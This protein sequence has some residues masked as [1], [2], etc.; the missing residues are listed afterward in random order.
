MIV[1]LGVTALGCA[2]VLTVGPTGTTQYQA[3]Q[4]AI[5]DAVDGDTV[6]VSP[7]VYSVAGTGAVADL[8]GKRI[9]LQS[10]HGPQWTTIAYE[11]VASTTGRGIRC[12]NSETP[13]T[14]IDGFRVMMLGSPPTGGL[15][16]GPGLQI[17]HA[18]PTIR[19]CSFESSVG[20]FGGSVIIR[21]SESRF[22]SCVFSD[23]RADIGGAIGVHDGSNLQF[24]ECTFE[25]NVSLKYGGGIF[26]GGNSW[27]HFEQC[28]FNRNS[29]A[30]NGGGLYCHG[31]YLRFM[32]CDFH[33][34]H[35]DAGGGAFA[36][37]GV[38]ILV[39]ESTFVGNDV[40]A[41][42]LGFPYFFG[43]GAICNR[44]SIMELLDCQFEQNRTEGDQPGEGF[45]GG[46]I[47][48]ICGSELYVDS[49]QF[50]QNVSGASGG[51][52]S[53]DESI[54]EITGTTMD[55][56]ASMGGSGGALMIRDGS[57]HVSD[58]EF[59]SGWATWGH[60]AGALHLNGANAFYERS[61]FSRG[62]ALDGG[63]SVAQVDSEAVYLDCEFENAVADENGGAMY[64]ENATVRI[65]DCTFSGS[66]AAGSGHAMYNDGGHVDI[67][68]SIF[69][70]HANEWAFLGY[71][72]HNVNGALVSSTDGSFCNNVPDHVLGTP[73]TGMGNMFEAEC[74]SNFPRPNGLASI[75]PVDPILRAEVQSN[76]FMV[77]QMASG[78][79]IEA[80]A[81]YNNSPFPPFANAE[82]AGIITSYERT[83]GS[84]SY[85][86]KT[87]ADL[88]ALAT[89]AAP[90]M[91]CSAS[92][93]ADTLVII[94]TL[95]NE[96]LEVNIKGLGPEAMHGSW[97]QRS[98]WV[99]VYDV[100]NMS[101]VTPIVVGD[102]NEAW[103]FS[104]SEGRTYRVLTFIEVAAGAS[105]VLPG[106][107]SGVERA[108]EERWRVNMDF[109]VLGDID[110]DGLVDGADLSALLGSW[111][112]VSPESDLNG[113]GIVDGGDLTLLLG[114]WG[115]S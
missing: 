26:V 92:V 31:D 63:G 17:N 76:G 20:D 45:D 46:A 75:S 107:S 3:I 39:S 9:T 5:D 79:G 102:I 72:I 57:V 40:G 93:Y 66:D 71:A 28:V 19:N 55:M 100:D 49:C 68:R 56:N 89:S 84:L 109:R 30:L 7:G 4:A 42:S 60:G 33:D 110:D 51:A 37:W 25:W 74:S 80:R 10:T 95:R 70:D 35:A 21:G 38:H 47:R 99:E 36:S 78:V 83:R 34:N 73:L 82:S 18:S 108:F 94:E 87:E 103:R 22:E 32:K 16:D 106:G 52:I 13:E 112:S 88:H 86:L 50:I 111:G 15:I 29:A 96:M 6:L 27:A 64:N 24:V 62:L 104:L 48:Q 41:S 91:Q 69:R 2:E 81:R 1:V 115:G 44:D 105:H 14:V 90:W 113:D 67:V 98:A 23:N 8:L 114:N 58:T 59:N 101:L 97:D 43:G 85:W 12:I 77:D 11:A 54:V 65:E 53:S 61:R